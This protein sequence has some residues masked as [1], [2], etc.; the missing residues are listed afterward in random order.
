MGSVFTCPDCDSTVRLKQTVA[1]GKKVRCPKCDSVVVVPDDEDEEEDRRTSIKAGASAPRRSRDADGEDEDRPRRKSRRRDEDDDDEDDRPRKK[2]KKKSGGVPVLVWVLLGVLVLA[3][4]GVGIYFAVSSGKDK[5]QETAKGDDKKDKDKPVDNEGKLTL[6]NFNKL[7]LQMTEEEVTRLI[8][9]S[10]SP[11][12]DQNF[13]GQQLRTLMWGKMNNP[14]SNS[15]SLIFQNGKLANGTG[16]VDNQNVIAGFPRVGGPGTGTD[17][18]TGTGSK[19][20]PANWKK[21]EDASFSQKLKNR[22]DAEA[23]L[24]PATASLGSQ[25]IGNET[26][27]E[28]LQWKDGRKEILVHFMPTYVLLQK[29]NL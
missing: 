6:E 27:R 3:G 19:V 11:P 16:R 15:A 28:T 29:K 21:L 8:G 26:S 12:M 9:P 7:K 1:G 2:K 14:N 25:R 4:G 17:P 18:G 23:I 13:G 22:A 10:G 5:E 24:G 20:T